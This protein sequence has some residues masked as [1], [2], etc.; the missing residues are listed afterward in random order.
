MEGG[1]RMNDGLLNLYRH[2]TWA[3]LQVIEFCQG[4]DDAHLDATVPGTYGTIRETLAHL[5]RAEEG[6]L[7]RIKNEAPPEPRPDAHTPL[8][9]L[10]Q[11][12][13]R[14]GPEWERV[15]QDDSLPGGE[16]IT[17]DG[18][19]VLAVVPMAQAVH[20]ACEH[21]AHVLTILGA[22]GVQAPDPDVWS[23]AEAHGLMQRI[24]PAPEGS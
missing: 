11:R 22:R 21:R 24:E 17:A 9:E 13:R 5:V 3:T 14:M 1:L 12:I 4:V 8:A 19:R 6:Y 2:M 23:Y 10:A 16:R 18:W 7:S 20:H 15:A